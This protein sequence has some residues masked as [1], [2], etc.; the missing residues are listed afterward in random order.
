MLP[1]VRP[2][3]ARPARPARPLPRPSVAPA[4]RLPARIGARTAALRDR[5]L[6][7][8]VGAFDVNRGLTSL[9]EGS[10][11]QVYEVRVWMEGARGNGGSGSVGAL[12]FKRRA[13]TTRPRLQPPPL[14]LLDS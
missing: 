13:R 3:A 6:A 10:Y 2:L 5:G 12:F 9:G 8:D 4:P 11:G 7:V 1:V 14:L